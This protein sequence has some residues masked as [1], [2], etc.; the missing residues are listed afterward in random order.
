MKIKVEMHEEI[1]MP[2]Y[3]PVTKVKE[4]KSKQS[5]RKKKE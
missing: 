1:L 5:K 2:K 4:K 3:E